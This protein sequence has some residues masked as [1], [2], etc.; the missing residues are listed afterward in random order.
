MECGQGTQE[1]VIGIIDPGESEQTV[2]HLVESVEESGGSPVVGTATAVLDS[3]PDA[4][5]ARGEAALLSAGQ[6]GTTVPIMPVGAGA[7]TRSVPE[8]A[9]E[10]ALGRLVS[11]RFGR[12][13]RCRYAVAVGEESAGLAISDTMLVTEDPA[14]ISEY[15][16]RSANSDVARFRADGLVVATPLGSHG[17]AAAAG[18]PMLA[19]G[20]GVVAVPVAQF[21]TDRDSWVLGAH[22]A[23]QLRVER[24]E[25]PIELLV[26]DER[27]SVVEPA[28]DITLTPVA[29]LRLAV[30]PESDPCWTE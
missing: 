6:T 13:E 24:D 20:T 26:D 7:G 4:I 1:T 23:V 15:S 17:Y 12:V 3:E 22:E 16:I 27:H 30:V 14:R 18:G 29:P 21:A 10:T 5:V 28:S 11:G 25:G 9:F 2:D 8:D 19:P